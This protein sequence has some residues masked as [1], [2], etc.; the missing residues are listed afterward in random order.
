[1]SEPRIFIA[2]GE[3][4]GDLHGAALAS[5]L[6]RLFPDAEM[7]GLAGPRMAMAGVTPIVEFGRL[8][9]MGFV[10][11]VY[12]LPFFL[13]LR[14]RVRRLLAENPPDLVIPID[15][16]GFNLRLAQEAHRRGIPVLYYVAPQ[17]WAWRQERARIL[18]ANTKRVAV[19]FPHEEPFLRDFGVD[20]V[21]VGHPLL[22]QA[23]GWESPEEAISA[24]EADPERPILGL[25]PGSRPQ[26]V[27]RMLGPFLAAA[28]EVT[29]RRPE[30]QVMVAGA[31]GVPEDYYRAARG[32]RIVEDSVRLLSAATAVLTKSGTTT[33]QAALMET[34]LVIGYRSHPLTFRLAKRLVR[35]DS[36]GMVNLLAG[37]RFAPEF[38]QE[39]PSDRIA[40]RLMP[41]LDRESADRKAMI[42]RLRKVRGLLGEPGAAARVA[43]LAADLLE[44]RK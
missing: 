5:A 30:V 39:L 37:E 24:I 13:S 4:S 2:A 16:P 34:P 14:R 29:R 26:E 23:S 8:T 35:V 31:S 36:I 42:D 21:F 7:T 44:R 43:R 41:L 9:V 6:R 33:I 3:A 19:V 15:Y 27:A 1:V 20:A 12:R 11:V 38:V 25:L 10:E 17:L 32:Y 22:D 28:A 40:A 18:A